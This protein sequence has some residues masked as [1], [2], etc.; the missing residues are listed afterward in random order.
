MAVQLIK[1]GARVNL[2]YP[3][4]AYPD[5]ILCDRCDQSYEFHY[6]AG[7]EHRLKEWLAKA[8]AAVGNS[9]AA[10]HPDTVAVPF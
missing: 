10:D 1:T 6:S 9:H 4:K 5:K 7:E 3:F 8:K 2:G